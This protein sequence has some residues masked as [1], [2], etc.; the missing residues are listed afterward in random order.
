MTA[1]PDRGD[2]SPTA[3]YTAW[4]WF[5]G[6]FS[7]A[8]L[9]AHR[10]AK[11]VFDAVNI[12]LF[13]ARWFIRGLR[14][15]KHS[16]VHRHAMIDTLLQRSGSRHVLELAAGLSRRGAA[17]T[18][19]PAMDYVE[20][21]L[22]HV[23]A[24]KEALL[25]RSPEGQDVAARANLRRVAADVAEVSL[26]TLRAPGPNVFVIAE[27]LL[28]YLS[29]DEQRDLFGRIRAILVQGGAFVFD[30]VPACEQPQPGWF[31]RFLGRLMRVFTRGRE[32]ERDQRT[33][34]DIV[35]DLRAAGFDTV[36]VLEPAAVAKE[37]ALPF[38]D[39]PTQQVLFV[40]RC[41]P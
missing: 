20:V 40:S 31:G 9:F 11:T 10:Q 7:Q 24:R 5:W 38:P 35:A 25:Q 28:M 33:R 37:W 12:A 14:S 3:L 13:F 19:D 16:L 34:D 15:L 23:V 2:L 30:L 41:A 17:F 18:A 26:A 21:D 39:V 22:P 8:H 29:A 27:G 36:E 1:K 32:F 6:G 4:T